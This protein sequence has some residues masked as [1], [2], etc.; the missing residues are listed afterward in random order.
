M[1][2]SRLEFSFHSCADRGR[3]ADQED[4]KF[5]EW[6]DE[7]ARHGRADRDA[8]SN[9]SGA[10]PADRG[11]AIDNG[12]ALL[13]AV[14]DGMG[15]H[16][17]G[18]VASALVID[19]FTREFR[20]G[21]LATPFPFQTA[22]NAGNGAIAD[23][24]NSDRSMSGMGSTLVAAH[25][26][27][28]GLRWGSV[29][30]SRLFLLRDGSLSLLNADHSYGA[31]LDRMAEA[32]SISVGEAQQHPKRNALLSALTGQPI[33]M[34]D[35]RTDPLPLRHGDWIILASDGID[36][37][38]FAELQQH[39]QS[40]RTAAPSRFAT[41]LISAVLNKAMPDQDNVT[42]IVV[43]VTE[44]GRA[45]ELPEPP[46]WLS[47]VDGIGGRAQQVIGAGLDARWLGLSLVFIAAGLFIVLLILIWPSNKLSS[48]KPPPG[49]L[50]QG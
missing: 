47:S 26:S 32:K 46:R 38:S 29:G 24:I 44:P 22:L 13:A 40:M 33:Q 3:R 36:T 4:S 15:G 25:L 16:A 5:V 28:D 20:E 18:E 9:G 45:R 48:P 41:G 37:L 21:A 8:G 12:R 35:V 31:V 34:Q 17:A 43:K 11:T 50:Q 6:L 39:A 10:V 49:V 7:P 1:T 2:T 30:D 27:E 23:R 14:A 19:G 42:L